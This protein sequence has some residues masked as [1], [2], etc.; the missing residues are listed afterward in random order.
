MKT[1][2][3]TITYWENDDGDEDCVKTTLIHALSLW[4]AEG[5]ILE[6]TLEENKLCSVT[7][8]S[9]FEVTQDDLVYNKS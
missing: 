8:I 4:E 9:G 6:I 7:G 3:V 1:F 2:V 5:I